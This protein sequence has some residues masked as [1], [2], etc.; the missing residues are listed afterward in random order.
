MKSSRFEKDKQLKD[1]ITKNARNLFRIKKHGIKNRIIRYTKSLF[2][3]EEKVIFEVTIILK[4][5]VTVIKIKGYQ[6]KNILIKL[7]YT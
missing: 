1:I 2:E 4:M 7:D 3:H 5:K 6:L